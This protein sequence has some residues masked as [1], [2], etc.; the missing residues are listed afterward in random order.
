MTPVFHFDGHTVRPVDESDRAYLN[1]LIAADPY[2]RE[3]LTAGYFLDRQPGEDAWAIEDAQ[4]DVV[5][6]FRTSTAVRIGIQFAAPQDKARNRIALV[7]GMH[8]L[9]QTLRRNHF[10]EIVFDTDAPQLAA[11][12]ERTLGFRSGELLTRYIG[13]PRVQDFTGVGTPGEGVRTFEPPPTPPEA[14]ET[15]PTRE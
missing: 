6:Y 10:R 8:W 15:L 9:E 2:H 14:L 4:G 3:R 7:R 5:L 13:Q 1:Q 11:F 12:A